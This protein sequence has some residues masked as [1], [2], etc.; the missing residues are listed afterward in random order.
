MLRGF[1][2]LCFLAA[3]FVAGYLAWVLLGTNLVTAAAQSELR[4]EFAQQIADPGPVPPDDAVRIPGRAIARLVIPRLDRA[5]IVIDGT[6]TADLKRGPG[7][8][9]ESALP[10]EDD[11]KVAIAGHRTTYGAPFFSLERMRE[12]DLIQLETEHGTFDYRV[13]QTR[14]V[15]PTA[16]Q[17]ADQTPRPTLILTTCEPRFS[18]AQRL[19]VF[20]DRVDAAGG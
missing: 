16:V 5:D 7:L 20:A 17:V 4:D 9:E 18:A 13:T 14:I 19:V 2:K 8:Y 1:G 3:A 6:S 12:G 15:A 11:G 10:W